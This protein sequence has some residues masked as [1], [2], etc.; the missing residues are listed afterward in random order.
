MTFSFRRDYEEGGTYTIHLPKH[1]FRLILF[2]EAPS[3]PSFRSTL[4]QPSQMGNFKHQSLRDRDKDRDG[5]RDR[6]RDLRDREGQERLRH[7]RNI[8]R[9]YFFLSPRSLYSYRISMTVTV[10]VWRRT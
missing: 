8:S 10:W 2:P 6:E 9:F 7:V 5:E 1:R 4:T 3:R